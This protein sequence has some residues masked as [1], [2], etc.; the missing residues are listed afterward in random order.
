MAFLL[1]IA[2]LAVPIAVVDHRRGVRPYDRL[3]R[4]LGTDG[5]NG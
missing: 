3:G 1:L 5:R 2:L 4:H